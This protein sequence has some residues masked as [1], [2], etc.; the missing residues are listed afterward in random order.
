MP[1]LQVV[2]VSML[3]AAFALASS[4][5]AQSGRVRI[6]VNGLYQAT[7][8]TFS[9]NRTFTSFLEEG[10]SSRSYDLGTG[11][12]FEVGAIVSFTTSIGVM[13]SYE[14]FDG[15]IDASFEESLPHPLFFNQ[16]R[17]LEGELSELSYKEQAVHLDA[18][19]THD[20]SS[21]TVDVFGG[22]T[23]FFTETE[24]LSTIRSRSEYPFDEVSLVSTDTVTLDDNPIG[25]NVGG[26]LTYRFTTH[27]GAAFQARYSQASLSVTPPDGRA[28]DFDAG[29][30][31]VG[32]GIRIDF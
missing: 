32:G 6:L 9:E 22:A 17:S 29:G 25:F 18:V 5:E 12:A 28:I 13:A 1:K 23:L 11:V 16:N 21:M 20:F 24:V 31:H 2:L 8:Q 3:A 27:L 7:S 15:T 10:T 30:F 26:S 14:I 4:A 19:F